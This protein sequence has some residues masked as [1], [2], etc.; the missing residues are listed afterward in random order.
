MN[1]FHRRE[2]V[3]LGAGLGLDYQFRRWL[4][5]GVDY[6]FSDRK[7]NFRNSDYTDHIFGLKVT[8]SL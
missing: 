4:G 5:F 1:R 8:L 2:D 6:T 3:L 7:S